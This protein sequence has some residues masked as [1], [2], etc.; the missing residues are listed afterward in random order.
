[1]LLWLSSFVG[2]HVQYVFTFSSLNVLSPLSNIVSLLSTVCLAAGL[3]YTFWLQWLGKI[4][5]FTASCL[6]LLI[7]MATGKV[8][9]PQYLIWVA[10]F[11]A[12]VGKSNWKWLVSWTVV[13]LLTTWIYPYIY[14]SA[15]IVKV[16]LLAPFYPAVLLRNVI[17][18][19]VIIVLLYQATRKPIS[20]PSQV[21]AEA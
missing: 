5:V 10:P 2:Y 3:L 19:G 4:D 18:L 21:A 13:G 1:M 12:Y 15:R 6:T 17:M 16:P 20:S 8:F 11:V 9:S 14:N 7:I